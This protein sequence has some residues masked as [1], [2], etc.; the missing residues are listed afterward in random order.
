MG[1]FHM[2]NNRQD[3]QDNIEWRE[4]SSFIKKK[5]TPLS[6][7]GDKDKQQPI[8]TFYLHFPLEGNCRKPLI[9]VDGPHPL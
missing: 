5:K 9:F 2:P 4:T 7:G 6:Y 8:K 1:Y 3:G